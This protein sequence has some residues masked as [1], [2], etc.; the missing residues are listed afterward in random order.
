MNNLCICLS[1]SFV[2][3]QQHIREVDLK[4]KNLERDK[5][6]AI[7]ELKKK[8]DELKRI[9][10]I[11]EKEEILENI[12]NLESKIR[13]LEKKSELQNVLQEELQLEMSSLARLDHKRHQWKGQKSLSADVSGHPI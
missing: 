10:R 9:T 12:N 11:N 2:L 4:R 8:Q 5:T 3:L 7:F 1:L 13:E 6:D